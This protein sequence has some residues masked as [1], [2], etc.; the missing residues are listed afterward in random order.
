MA[1]HITYL[2]KTKTLQTT[3]IDAVTEKIK[4]QLTLRFKTK[5]RDS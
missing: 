5:F 4:K 1:F 2:D 3:E